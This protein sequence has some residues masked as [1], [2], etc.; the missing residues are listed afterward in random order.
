MHL[1]G[2]YKVTRAAYPYFREQKF[3]RIVNVASAAGIYG[4]FGQSNYGA[5]KLGIVGFT[6]NIAI[7]GATKNIKANVIAPLARSRMT[8]DVWPEEVKN[9]MKPEHITPLVIYLAHE[10]CVDSG[11][12]FEL[13][14]GWVARLRWQRTQGVIFDTTKDFTAE[15]IAKEWKEIN[16]WKDAENPTADA[17]VSSVMARIAAKSAAPAASA[18]ASASAAPAKF[19]GKSGPYFSLI[20]DAVGREGAD[21]CKKVGG[22][23]QWDILDGNKKILAQ[24][25]L[26]LKNAP[27][28]FVSGPIDKPNVSLSMS[29]DDFCGLAEGKLNPQS[30]FMQGKIKMKGSMALAMKLKVILDAA[31]P[32]SKI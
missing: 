15:S 7:E 28:K 4:N 26:D 30:A 14:A 5:A 1:K 29:D 12:L 22:T 31:K 8:D 16:N 32:K 27:G 13:A 19:I 23:I 24:Y 10:S 21:L 17:P 18:S 6:N 3:G 25:G 2:T 9:I 11:G 20:Q